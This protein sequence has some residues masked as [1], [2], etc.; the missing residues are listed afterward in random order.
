MIMMG[1]VDAF[2]GDKLTGLY[3]IQKW[4]QDNFIKIVGEPINKKSYRVVFLDDYRKE[5]NVVDKALASIEANGTYEK[6]YKK[7]FGELVDT[8]SLLFRRLL[9]AALAVIAVGFIVVGLV[10]RWNRALKYQ[11]D[12]RTADLTE[13]N[14]KLTKQ[15]SV[16]ENNDRFK[17]E[18]LNSLLSGIVTID[19]DRKITA[20][21]LNG[22][23][24]L[25]TS[26]DELKGR[27]IDDTLLRD[28]L[29][30]F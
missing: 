28:I 17:K 11:V 26:L 30:A 5:K 15:K 27:Y 16:L 18:I 25:G 20:I 22:Q 21:N 2:I 14:I 9:Y 6:I 1:Q 3:T 19:K 12:L 4:K 24:I 23:R 8:N 7:W 29:Y 10:I 13:A